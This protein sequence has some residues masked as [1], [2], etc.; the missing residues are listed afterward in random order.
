MLRVRTH[1][2]PVKPDTIQVRV[3]SE[4]LRNYLQEH[5]VGIK[6]VQA[7][8][9][10]CNHCP[11]TILVE[12]WRDASKFGWAV[13][14]DGQLQLCPRCLEAHKRAIFGDAVKPVQ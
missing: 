6:T 2:I 13:P 7:V 8:E 12:H 3:L 4:L 1:A 10:G 5:N 11:G 9:V 14:V